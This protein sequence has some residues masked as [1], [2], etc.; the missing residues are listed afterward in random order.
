MDLGF[1]EARVREI[2]KETAEKG[3]FE[4]VRSEIAGT[5]RSPVVR[6]FIDKAEGLTVEHCAD[7][8][9]E[10][11]ARLDA[12]DLIPS[13][14]VL[15]VSSP[16]LERELYSLDDFRRF[17]GKLV[18]VKT[19]EEIDGSKMHIGRIDSVVGDNVRL[20]VNDG[21]YVEMPFNAI[22]KAN[23]RIELNEEFRKR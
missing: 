14:Y 16:G 9:R 7:V 15:E 11:D 22:A 3:G 13:K 6:I 5:K 12:E 10:I 19:N 20:N 4:F 17:S 8:S 18:K 21:K 1:V 23:L 2:A